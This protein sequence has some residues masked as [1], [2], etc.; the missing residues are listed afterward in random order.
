[1]IILYTCSMLAPDLRYKLRGHFSNL[2][3]HAGFEIDV[4]Q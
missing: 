3:A 1:M 2:D 4:L